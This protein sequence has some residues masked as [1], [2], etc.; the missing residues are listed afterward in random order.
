MTTPW[1]PSLYQPS[2]GGILL[3][4]G[5]LEREEGQGRGTLQYEFALLE[6]H[7]LRPHEALNPELLKETE[8][9]IRRDG[10]VRE[11]ILVEGGH[12]VILD[13]H[14]RYHALVNLGCRRI[15][16]YVVDYF[17]DGIRV[18]T[19][20]GAP[21]DRVPKEEVIERALNGDLFPPKTT[22]HMVEDPPGDS[23]VD[24]EALR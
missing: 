21:V 14:H 17:Q 19:W 12:H 16:V 24:L 22:K 5:R 13:G 2:W 23:P 10:F 9:A 20:P 3:W 18:D 4:P 11:P 1:P 7:R 15:P 6:A 8:E